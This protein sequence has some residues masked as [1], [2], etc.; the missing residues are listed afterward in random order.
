MRKH[1]V[2]FY[3]PGT[4]VSESSTLSIEDWDTAKAVEMAKNIQERHGAKPYGFRFETR[5]NHADVQ[6]AEGVWLKVQEK[7]VKSSGTYFLGG[8]LETFDDVVARNS[9]KENILRSNMEGNG[10]WIVC[11]NTNSYRSTM[12]FEE[13]D[14]IVDEK[15]VVVEAGD[16]PKHVNYRNAQTLKRKAK[17]GY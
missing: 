11:I 3:S 10:M 1:Y 8:K 17:H 2:T 6:D 5:L 4:F 12:P 15:G 9:D 16:D 7:T 13:N 14:R